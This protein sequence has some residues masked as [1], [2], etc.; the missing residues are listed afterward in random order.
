MIASGSVLKQ[1]DA[2]YDQGAEGKAYFSI[3]HP[4][5]LPTALETLD[6]DERIEKLVVTNTV[7]LPPEKR[8][9]KV[10]VLSVASLLAVIINSIHQGISI[11]ERIIM[12]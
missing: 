8:H 5:L 6:N 2:L 12:E 9:P 7:P 3:T 4:I 1:I 10:E 11:S